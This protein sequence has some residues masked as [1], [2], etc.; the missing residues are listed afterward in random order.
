MQEKLIVPFRHR[1]RQA[2]TPPMILDGVCRILSVSC[3][4]VQLCAYCFIRN[5]FHG[6]FQG[7]T[8]CN[9]LF[10]GSVDGLN[11]FNPLTV[12]LIA[13][14]GPQRSSPCQHGNDAEQRDDHPVHAGH[15]RRFLQGQEI[16]ANEQQGN[17]DHRG[18]QGGNQLVHK[19]EQ[20][21][22]NAGNEL[23]GA[24]GLIVRAVGHHG[25]G[26]IG[27]GVVCAIADAKAQNEGDGVQIDGQTFRPEQAQC[28]GG[29]TGLPQQQQCQY[30]DVADQR[31]AGKV[32][33]DF[34]CPYF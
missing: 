7:H 16:D 8:A 13:L 10:S 24:I 14:H 5:G 3:G 1:A 28:G 12:Q 27:G 17:G 32:T 4:T 19:A 31:Q 2:H 22:H 20:R 33:R 26:H 25:N 34:F 9:R 15:I 18:S 29:V 30:A 23:A 6:L 21:T 11:R